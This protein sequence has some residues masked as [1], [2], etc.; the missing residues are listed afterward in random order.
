MVRLSG[1]TTGIHNRHQQ[2]VFTA[3]YI[4]SGGKA[5]AEVNQLIA[6]SFP[7]GLVPEKCIPVAKMHCVL[8]SGTRDVLS[9]VEREQ[10]GKS[11][12]VV[13]YGFTKPS[14]PV[15]AL[16]VHCPKTLPRSPGQS[17][18]GVSSGVKQG[19]LCASSP[20]M[21]QKLPTERQLTIGMRM[22][23]VCRVVGKSGTVRYRCR[24]KKVH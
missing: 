20:D 12:D 21:I 5:V 3:L 14:A 8:I 9:A 11:Y 22:G 6:E 7:N 10:I 19:S 13:V 1:D 18:I 4:R 2:I 23:A 24:F 16:L 17:F 15:Q